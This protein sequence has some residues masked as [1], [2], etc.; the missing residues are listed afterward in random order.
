VD[1][2]HNQKKKKKTDRKHCRSRTAYHN[3]VKISLEKSKDGLKKVL[4]ADP[5]KNEFENQ[6]QNYDK[7]EAGELTRINPSPKRLLLF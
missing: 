2:I 6:E 3:S 1:A 7:E 4:N 5:P